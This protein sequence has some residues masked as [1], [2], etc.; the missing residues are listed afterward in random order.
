MAHTVAYFKFKNT[1]KL[2]I[3]SAK[4]TMTFLEELALLATKI[5]TGR[6]NS[7]IL[8]VSYCNVFSSAYVETT[9]TNSKISEK[10]CF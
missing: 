5:N 4:K 8:Q 6:H 1:W 9:L 3:I 10:L 7:P 2:Q